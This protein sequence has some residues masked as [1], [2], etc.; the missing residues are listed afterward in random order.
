MSVENSNLSQFDTNENIWNTVRGL[1]RYI[2][3]RS[4]KIREAKVPEEA[5]G[6]SLQQFKAAQSGALLELEMI[7]KRLAS[8]GF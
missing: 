8:C 3:E 5:K 7:D 6:A 1:R 2:N 4:K